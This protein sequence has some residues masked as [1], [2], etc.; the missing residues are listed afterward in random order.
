M[1][2]VAIEHF[3]VY[4]LTPWDVFTVYE[5]PIC[6]DLSCRLLPFVFPWLD[7]KIHEKKINLNLNYKLISPNQWHLFSVLTIGHSCLSNSKPKEKGG[8]NPSLLPQLLSTGNIPI[9]GTN[10]MWTGRA[11]ALSAT[12]TFKPI[13]LFLKCC[14]VMKIQF[15]HQLSPFSSDLLPISSFTLRSALIFQHIFILI[16]D[17]LIGLART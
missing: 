12:S 1:I 14:S 17:S 2:V 5:I 11:M 16:S 6:L 4:C 9:K 15:L 3:S 8:K 10:Y 13:Y 7:C